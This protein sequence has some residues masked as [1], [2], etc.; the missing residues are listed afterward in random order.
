MRIAIPSAV[1]R[2]T[3][4]DNFELWNVIYCQGIAGFAAANFIQ[5][6]SRL[7]RFDI[8]MAVTQTKKPGR[9]GAASGAYLEELC[10]FFEN[11]ATVGRPSSVN[12]W[13]R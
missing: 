8:L 4:R 5:C 9:V 11:S 12:A 1:K 3:D 13:L 10:H 7:N 6:Q 2:D